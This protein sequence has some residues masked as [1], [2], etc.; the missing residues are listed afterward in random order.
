MSPPLLRTAESLEVLLADLARRGAALEL[1]NERRARLLIAPPN[2]NRHRLGQWLRSRAA[3]VSALRTAVESRPQR[4][5][6]S[7]SHSASLGVAAVRTSPHKSMGATIG[8]D[9]ELAERS[10]SAR[11]AKRITHFADEVE[12]Y[13]PVG[14]WC[15]K[16]AIF[17]T[18]GVGSAAFREISVDLPNATGSQ[19]VGLAQCRSL[20]FEVGITRSESFLIAVALAFGSSHADKEIA[21]S[22]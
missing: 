17:K 11:L 20:R 19:D 8:I 22:T 15:L 12:P 3:L 7:L 10:V 9:C 13:S 21:P 18:G 1:S 2:A 5:S 6:L 4:I 14:L 16:E